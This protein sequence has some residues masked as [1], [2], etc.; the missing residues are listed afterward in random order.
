MWYLEVVVLMM[1][2]LEV[3]VLMMSR[4]CGSKGQ[5]FCLSSSVTD[6]LMMIFIPMSLWIMTWTN[7]NR[8]MRTPLLVF[9]L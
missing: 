9:I 8:H 2:Y 6:Q 5:S 3:V 1:W 4:S 7:I